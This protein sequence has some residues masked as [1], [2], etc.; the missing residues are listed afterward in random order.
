MIDKNHA[1]FLDFMRFGVPGAVEQS[2]VRA[3]PSLLPLALSLWVGGCS[4]GPAA[5]AVEDSVTSGRISVV[6]AAEA[7]SLLEKERDRFTALYPQATIRIAGGTSR[8]AV[9]ALFGAECD[10]AVLSRELT[11][12]E[13]GAASR[14]GLEL[15]GY[16]FAKDAVVVVVNPANPVEN[17][18]LDDLRRI[19]EGKIMNWA[20]LGATAG[21]IV[22]VFPPP[23][24]DMADYFS[25]QVMGG[26]PVRARVLIA[27]SDSEAVATVAER[28]G[29]IAFVSVAWAERGAKTLR[30]S[31]L[32]GLPYW[33]PD[34]E[35]IHRGDY[36]L[37]RSLSLYLRAK[38]PRLA[39]G[40]V[41]FIT[42]RDGQQIVHE[43]GLVP[44]SVPV[45]FV[46][47]SPMQGAH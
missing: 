13:R 24:S 2:P 35:A 46:R 33:K 21:A 28:A 25:E 39:Q 43:R 29:A 22:P 20:E 26:Q 11:P 37:T 16:R 23:E 45:R 31:T 27:A 7:V 12:E 34:I 32:Q 47:R 5:K 3:L 44:T 9:R 19:Y 41:T 1:G 15:E 18:A 17:M 6:S 4:S 10:A 30:I 36:P 40:L 38:G 42:S 14:G 8:D